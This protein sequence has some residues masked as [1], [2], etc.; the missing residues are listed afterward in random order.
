MARERDL[1]SGREDPVAIVGRGVRRR[2]DERGLREIHLPRDPAHL[3]GREARRPR[4]HRERIAGERRVREDVDPPEIEEPLGHARDLGPRGWRSA[5]LILAR[6]VFARA[7]L[8]RR[9]T[10]IPTPTS[11]IRQ[12]IAIR[13][14]RVPDRVQKFPE[15]VIREMTRIA[16][17]HGA[18][19]LAQ[20]DP[21]FEPP[22]ELT[23]AAK[24]APDGGYNQYSTTWGARGLR[25]A[26][27]RRGEA[28]HG[29]DAGR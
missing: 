13:D 16:A 2:E 1:A 26:I 15:S 28:L 20:G 21:D 23:A 22:P 19:N 7:D 24:R 9:G 4:E 18:V 5:L 29:V 14:R 8:P 6:Q 11:A 3:D 25:A 27:P 10:S 17:L 12:D